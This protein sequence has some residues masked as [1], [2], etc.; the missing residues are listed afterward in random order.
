M[1]V[2]F[3]LRGL[4]TEIDTD[5]II[6]LL[7]AG[8]DIE[9]EYI[10]GV[11]QEL[12]A[13]CE[14]LEPLNVSILD[15]LSITDKQT[16]DIDRLEAELKQLKEE[17][18]K[19]KSNTHGIDWELFATGKIVVQCETE[20]DAEEFLEEAIKRG[21]KTFLNKTTWQAHRENTCFNN[22]Y[23]TF[24][25]NLISYCY[26]SYYESKGIKVVKWKPDEKEALYDALEGVQVKS[27]EIIKK[28]AKYCRDLREESKKQKET[29]EFY[30]NQCEELRQSCNDLREENESIKNDKSELILAIENTRDDIKMTTDYLEAIINGFSGS[31]KFDWERFKTGNIAVHCKT[32]KEAKD[33]IGKSI[34]HIKVWCNKDKIDV[35]HTYWRKNE[36][37]TC[38]V[39]NNVCNNV[40]LVVSSRET[41]RYCGR[42][43]LEWSDYM[44]GCNEQ[45]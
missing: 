7:K 41:S 19:A 26:K 27:T 21:F 15:L 20:K 14:A 11:I 24:S 9:N 5:A 31:D 38:Y 45:A 28:L 4:K 17:N 39:C 32:R 40:G 18:E 30:K 1:V 12:V 22:S 2:E 33:F 35:E 36:N 3:M 16:K 44:V 6:S 10:I 43:I 13:K 34:R 37:E 23:Y 42:E 29:I 8:N 25:G